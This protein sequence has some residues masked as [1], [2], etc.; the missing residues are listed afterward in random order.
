MS[1]I[2]VAVAQSIAVPGDVA[3]SVQDHVRLAAQAAKQGARLVLFPELS[4]TGY[5]RR[6]TPAD[7]LPPADP[8]LQPLQAL[9]DARE[10]VIIAGAPIPSPSGLH[11]GALCFAPHRAVTTYLKRYL[12]AG[13]EVTFTAGSGGDALRVAGQVVCVAI[14]ADITHAEHAQTA[15][16]QGAGI[17]AAS[18]FITPGGY[19]TDAGL[20]VGYARKHRMAVLMANYG[21]PTGGWMAAGRSAIWSRKGDLLACGPAEGEAVIVAHLAE[22]GSS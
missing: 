10:V 2:T 5:D 22:A 11:I 13:E 12:H 3:R 21:V 4:L 19:A 9:A 8:R 20:L 18:C 7:A 1:E 6:L 17:Y 16:T 14:C 15:V